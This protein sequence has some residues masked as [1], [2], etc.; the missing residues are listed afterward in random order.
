MNEGSG[1][2]NART[3]ELCES[4]CNIRNTKTWDLLRGQGE[5]YTYGKR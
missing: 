2:D 3:K 4:E 1:D 5:Q